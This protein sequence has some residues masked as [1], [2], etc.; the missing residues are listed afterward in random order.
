MFDQSTDSDFPQGSDHCPVYASI[1]DNIPWQDGETNIR[2]V[3]NPEGMFRAG[4]RLRD[5]S[6]K[7]TPALSGKLLPEFDRRRSI[8]D[9]FTKKPSLKNAQSSTVAESEDSEATETPGPEPSVPENGILS[10]FSEAGCS[11]SQKSEVAGDERVTLEEVVSTTSGSTKRPRSDTP[12]N[13]LTKR[14]KS[15]SM[16]APTGTPGKA[17]QSL[18]G[19]FKPKSPVPNGTSPTKDGADQMGGSG[20]DNTSELFAVESLPESSQPSVSITMLSAPSDESTRPAKYH[21]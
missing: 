18:K 16:P 1:K 20:L 21:P 14:S 3:M 19:F 13:R 15:G 4:K 6:M 10:S 2:D 9:M 7:D 5:S 11:Q 12:S 8:R 17:Q